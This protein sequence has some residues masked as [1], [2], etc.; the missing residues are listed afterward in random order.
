MYTGATSDTSQN[1]YYIFIGW[2]TSYFFLIQI[3]SS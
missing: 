3:A 1:Y 2:I